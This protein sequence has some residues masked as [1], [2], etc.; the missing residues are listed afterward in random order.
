MNFFFKN[1]PFGNAQVSVKYSD[2]K[3]NDNNLSRPTCML[4][5]YAYVRVVLDS[6][7]ITDRLFFYFACVHDTK[8]NEILLYELKNTDVLIIHGRTERALKD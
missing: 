4:L 8:L 5:V 7:M 6:C 2:V 3:Y 1:A